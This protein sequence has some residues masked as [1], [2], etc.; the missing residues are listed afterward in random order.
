MGLDDT[1]AADVIVLG[2]G[3]MFGHVAVAALK[4]RYAVVA[5]ARHDS[6]EFVSYD[7]DEQD[8]A[9]AAIVERAHADAIIVNAIATTASQ[10]AAAETHEHAFRVN[11][12]FPH[13]LARIA[14]QQKQRVVHIST[15]A[16]FPSNCGIVSEN[17]PIGPQDAYGVS[18][19]AG[20]LDC[21]HCLT[22]RCSIIGPP[23]PRRRSGVWA[24]VADQAPGADI[25]G[26]VNQLWSGMTTQQLAEVCVALVDQKCFAGVRAAGA[27][28]HLASNPVTSKYDL[29]RELAAL[30]RP[31]LT[32][33]PAQARHSICR[34]LTSRHGLLNG[35]APYWPTWAETLA[36]ANRRF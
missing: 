10:M 24:W 34:V 26:Y 3:G 6:S 11:A 22:I 18:K 35:L 31:D 33:Q 16:V 14:A 17:D 15:D 7:V 36:A 19:A 27:V 21:E 30:L 32:V 12:T 4:R 1:K 20:E 8:A 5:T 13:R 28:H 29:V 23:A 9:L 2:A 25:P